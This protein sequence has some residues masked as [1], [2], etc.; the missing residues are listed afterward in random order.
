[1]ERKID[2]KDLGRAVDKLKAGETILIEL[3]DVEKIKKFQLLHYQIASLENLFKIYA[4]ENT[5]M[6][7]GENFQKFTETYSDKYV[8]K[9]KLYNDII[10]GTFGRNLYKTLLSKK[11]IFQIDWE[12]Y[13]IVLRK[14]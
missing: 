12:A 10:V 14:G 8:E 5:E 4:R 2:I 7:S 3:E 1:M 11:V 9:Q 13:G 6:A